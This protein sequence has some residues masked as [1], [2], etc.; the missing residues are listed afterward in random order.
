MTCWLVHLDLPQSTLTY[1]PGGGPTTAGTPRLGFSEHG[2]AE[3]QFGVTPGRE[4]A[5][6]IWGFT[7]VG[8]GGICFQENG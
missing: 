6:G 5:A 3:D 8:L 2:A 7:P 4:P 1:I